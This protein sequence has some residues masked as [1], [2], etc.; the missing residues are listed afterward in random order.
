MP[1]LPTTVRVVGGGW[2]LVHRCFLTP[3]AGS[4]GNFC[5]C[6]CKVQWLVLSL[7]F[8]FTSCPSNVVVVK[9]V[10]RVCCGGLWLLN[11][12]DEFWKGWR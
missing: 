7:A 2:L 1:L 8:G 3:T 5:V 12:S 10:V 9:V 6:G 11:V 4:T